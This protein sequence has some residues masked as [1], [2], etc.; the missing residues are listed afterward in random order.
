MQ[1][2]RKGLEDSITLPPHPS[3]KGEIQEVRDAMN[4]RT[5]KDVESARNHDRVPFYAIKKYCEDN[6]INYIKEE[7]NI[8][9]NKRKHYEIIDFYNDTFLFDQ[10]ACTSPQT[11]YWMGSI[12]EIRIAPD[13]FW[14]YSAVSAL[15]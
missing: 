1:F 9:L 5:A 4:N 11:V 6:F 7:Y 14:K 10:N 15:T 12:D 3:S 13:V 2:F 8:L